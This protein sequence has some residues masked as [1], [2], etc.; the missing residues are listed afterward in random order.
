M[1]LALPLLLAAQAPDT[2]STEGVSMGGSF[3]TLM[4][5]DHT[6][7]QI[8]LM[9]ELVIGKVGIGLDVDIL[10]DEDGNWRK[11]DWDHFDDYLKKVYYVRYGHRG[12]PFYGRIGGFTGYTLGHGLIMRD[13]TNMLR[14]PDERQI[15]LQL[16]G[17]IPVYGLQVEGFSSNI[18]ENDILAARASATPLQDMALPLLPAMRVGAT[19]ATDRNQYDGLLDTDDDNYPDVFDDYPEDKHWHNEIDK[20]RNWWR[21]VY[22]EINHGDSTGFDNWFATSAYLRRNPSADDLGEE[23]VSILGLDYELPLLVTDAFTLTH[24]GELAKIIDHNMGFI[25]PGFG[26]TFLIFQVTLE[27]RYYQDDFEPAFF[28]NLYDE[29]RVRVI[30]IGEDSLGVL[31]KSQTIALNEQMEGWYGSV[32]AS[33]FKILYLKLAYEDMYGHN[34]DNGKSLWAAA[35]LNKTFI[36]KVTTARVDYSQTRVEHVLENLKSPST[37]VTAR[38]GYSMSAN[39]E[40]MVKYQER[41]VDLNGDGHIRGDEETVSTMSFGLQI[42]F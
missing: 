26:M 39:T 18:L 27:H 1:L 10:I 8:R 13:Y 20:H 34:L 16:G 37:L 42:R 19:F 17:Q 32:T 25:W 30:S 11:E 38:V 5:G 24:Y 4:V 22:T 15:G 3:G 36:P 14:Y 21:D 23:S 6:Y 31:A 28:D 12:D 2:T 41:Y 7:T 35:W 40:L 33:L 29:D 9:P